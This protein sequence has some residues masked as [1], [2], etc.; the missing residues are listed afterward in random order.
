MGKNHDI[1]TVPYDRAGKRTEK[2]QSFL[3]GDVWHWLPFSQ[4]E[5]NEDDQKIDMPQWL[6]EE[7]DLAELAE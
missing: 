7:K 5:I 6:C 1:V 4:I 3:F 2:A